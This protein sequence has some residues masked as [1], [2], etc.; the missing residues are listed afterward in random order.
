MKS[1]TKTEKNY[2]ENKLNSQKL[3]MAYDSGISRIHQYLNAEIEYVRKMLKGNENILEL[4]AGYGRIIK[5]LA[6]NCNSILGIDI[7]EDSIKLANE[8]LKNTKNT[9]MLVMDVH[10]LK[11]ENSFDVILCL[12][13]GL[14]AMKLTIDT[15]KNIMK[16]LSPGGQAFFSSYSDKFWDV[17]LQW[18]QEQAEKGLLG[19]ID[20]EKTKN[21]VIICKD[22]FKATTSTPA[23]LEEIGKNL[24]YEFKVEE[25]DDS[26]I[27]LVIK[28]IKF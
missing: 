2:Y 5:E 9:K 15:I 14:S 13:N 27:F 6:P 24:G 16:F 3:F 12:Q 20:M 21:G 22:G 4:G 17:R 18:F 19:E 8:Y 25:V 11:F 7:S 28:K 10:N 26:S 1:L 23:M